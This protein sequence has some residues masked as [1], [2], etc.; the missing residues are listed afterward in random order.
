MKVARNRGRCFSAP[1]P[2]GISKPRMNP[3]H[4][5]PS[6]SDTITTGSHSQGLFLPRRTNGPLPRYRW[7]RLSLNESSITLIES[8]PEAEPC[9][10]NGEQ[11][12]SAHVGFAL[13]PRATPEGCLLLYACRIS[14]RLG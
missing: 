7:L 1:K 4:N 14:A 5:H 13:S 11:G 6:G 3:P 2:V 12:E 10:T 8:P 9:Y